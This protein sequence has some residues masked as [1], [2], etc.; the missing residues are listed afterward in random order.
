[1]I[2]VF[3][4]GIVNSKEVKKAN[5]LNQI[6]FKLLWTQK[7]QQL[8]LKGANIN[9]V[10]NLSTQNLKLMKEYGYIGETI[11]ISDEEDKTEPERSAF[12]IKIF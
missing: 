3:V 1:M 9:N 7:I 4:F 11:P 8:E 5:N 2:R 10:K 12:G 6:S